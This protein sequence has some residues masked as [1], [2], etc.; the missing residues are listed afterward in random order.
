MKLR[1]SRQAHGHTICVCIKKE[2]KP[3]RTRDV[4]GRSK[5]SA[6]PK[7]QKVIK[8]KEK[9]MKASRLLR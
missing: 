1:T 5:F 2:L 4:G 3:Y 7:N 9:C 8:I 6:E